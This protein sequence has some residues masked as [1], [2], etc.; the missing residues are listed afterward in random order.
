MTRVLVVHHDLDT[1]DQEVE[2][3][4]RAGFHVTECCGPSGAPRPCPVLRGQPCH[5]AD[6]ADVL[7]YDVWAT[8]T[9]DSSHSLIESLRGQ[10]PQ[11]PIVLTSPG[12][13]PDWVEDEEEGGHVVTVL[14]Q[15][16]RRRL[17]EAIDRALA[18][19]PVPV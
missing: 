5:L 17:Q 3:L 1:A 7:V 15:P 4:R 12:L 10:Y 11:K 13:E 8:G 14:G 16:S 9:T 18:H 19:A 6:A 2:S